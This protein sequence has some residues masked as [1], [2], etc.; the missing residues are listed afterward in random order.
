METT[1]LIVQF[2][3]LG[4]ASVLAFAAAGSC[5]GVRAAGL[6]AVG[7]WKKGFVRNKPAPFIPL[8]AFIGAP[9]SQTFYGLIL[10]NKIAEVLSHGMYF[11]FV[12]ALAGIVIGLSAYVQGLIG[13]AAAD[14]MGE[15]EKGFTNYIAALGIIESV[16][17]FVMVFTLGLIGK[18][19]G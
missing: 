7:A 12:G 5:L 4:V 14:A 3:D 18:M 19:V 1:G 6:A 15:S 2:K 16:A 8:L 17:I 10:M 9:L 11:W 13:A